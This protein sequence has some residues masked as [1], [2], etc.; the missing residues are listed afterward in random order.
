MIPGPAEL[1]K[2]LRFGTVGVIVAGLYALSYAL[3]VEAGLATVTAN[4]LA[5]LGA[6][7][8]QFFGHRHFTFRATVGHRHALPR[9]LAVNGMGLALS[10]ALAFTL[11]DVL[12]FNALLTGAVVSLGLAAMN[13]VIFQR[14]VFRT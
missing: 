3:L 10:T 1:G 2:L 4:L 9:F 8:V 5:Y 12:G 11:R 6:I 14:W 7:S 13:W